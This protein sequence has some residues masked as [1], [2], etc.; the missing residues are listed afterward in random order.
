MFVER[1]C[2]VS[3]DLI[4]ILSTVYLLRRFSNLIVTCITSTSDDG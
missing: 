1:V 4:R 3:D 2:D